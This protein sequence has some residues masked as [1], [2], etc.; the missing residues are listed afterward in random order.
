MNTYRTVP[1]ENGRWGVVWLVDGQVR[2][3]VVGTF[4]TEAEATF[5]VYELAR[6][7]R[8]EAPRT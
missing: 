2:G 4:D 8:D 6:L 1:L 3:E 7:E 5:R